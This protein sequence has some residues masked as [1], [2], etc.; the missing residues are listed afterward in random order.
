MLLLPILH[1]PVSCGA[2]GLLGDTHEAAP[3]LHV[4]FVED[5]EEN[6]SLAVE[7]KK[8]FIPFHPQIYKTMQIIFDDKDLDDTHYDNK[9]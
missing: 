9:K 6:L 4:H 7:S 5:E 2:D 3:N 1:Y 8:D